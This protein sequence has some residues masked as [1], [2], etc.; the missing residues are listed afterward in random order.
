MLTSH[1]A[2]RCQAGKP[3]ALQM[4]PPTVSA[5]HAAHCPACSRGL[6]AQFYKAQQA[7][8]RKF[9][10]EV[11]HSSWRAVVEAAEQGV[12]DPELQ[13]AFDAVQRLG[14]PQA[15]ATVRAIRAAKVGM[16]YAVRRVCIVS[17][18]AG[19]LLTLCSNTSGEGESCTW[20][21]VAM[22][23]RMEIDEGH[24]LN[25]AGAA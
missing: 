10:R 22:C 23:K 13:G 12:L 1:S 17:A 7:A 19:G 25:N 24:M 3:A 14:V 9:S 6:L 21:A 20:R 8:R 5:T 2:A 18:A 16:D 11:Y 15:E 4:L